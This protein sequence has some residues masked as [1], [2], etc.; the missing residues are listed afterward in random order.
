M[1]IVL[2]PNRSFINILVHLIEE[3]K[4]NGSSLFHFIESAESLQ[5]WKT[6]G[7]KT[8][9][10]IAQEFQSK[11]AKPDYDK[12]IELI[13]TTWKRPTWKEQNSIFAQ[14]LRQVNGEMEIDPLKYRELKLKTCLKKWDAKDDSGNPVPL[15][16]ENIDNLDPSVAAYFLKVFEKTTE[17]SETDLSN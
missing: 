12:T 2:D 11:T 1:A 16:A 4:K 9:E 6:K 8:R 17:P 13:N 10:E 5:E 7:F 15:N 3:K 14:A